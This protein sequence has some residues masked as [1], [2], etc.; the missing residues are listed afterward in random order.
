MTSESTMVVS[1]LAGGRKHSVIP[2]NATTTIHYLNEEII[3]AKVRNVIEIE[4]FHPDL[5]SGY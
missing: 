1:S 4:P 3:Q 5:S 2:P